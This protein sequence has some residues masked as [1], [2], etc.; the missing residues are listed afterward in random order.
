[1]TRTD[2]HDARSMT[3]AVL[4]EADLPT[5]W[6]NLAA[7]LPAPMPPHLHP[8]TGRPL[9]PEDMAP[10]FPA[11]LIEQE[12][13]TERFVPIPEP[14]REVYRLWRPSPLYR[15]HRLERALGTPARIYYK[16]EGGS[17]VGSHKPNTAVAQAYYNAAEGV[18]RLTTETGAGQWGSA[19]S[20]ACA[21]F[22][23]ECEV[24]QVR[25][26]YD[27]KPYRRM[28]M[29]TYGG[30]VHPS[31]SDLTEAGRGFLERFPDTTGSLGMAVSEAVES[32][33]P[34]PQARYA[35]GSV[36]N[37]VLLHQT[38]I[39]EEALRQLEVFAE[40]QADV[41]FGCAGGG[42]NL[43][44]LSFPF[45]REKLA[46]RTTTRVVAMEPTAC[47]SLTKGRYEYDHGDVA[48]LTPLLKMHTLGR[49]FVPDPI[50]AGGLRY[51][52]MAPMVSHAVELG[53]ITAEAIGQREAFDA[54]VLFARAEGLVPAPESCHAIAGAVT[55]ARRRAASGEEGVL[56]IGLS[57]NGQL[58]L[59]AY[60]EHLTGTA[61]PT[62]GDQPF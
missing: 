42:S 31:P 37:H 7:D 33:A 19:L 3:V 23:M 57:G 62:A 55:E 6:Y 28:L 10:L 5:H 46:G 43:A 11:A 18:R 25:A 9:A 29:Q 59:P 21:L 38:V 8:G 22:G 20:F 44:G 2:V 39:G 34:D 26:S 53:L 32:A 56:V 36:L 52:G 47:P 27:S 48:G 61:E 35:L 40:V 41:V 45:L 60:V 4:G 15:A 12:A 54:G 1:M 14:V 50:H 13:S 17:P 51:H 58:D 49:D 30:V 24:W 16:Y